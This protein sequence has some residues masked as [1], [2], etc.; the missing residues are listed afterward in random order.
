MAAPRLVF[1]SWIVAIVALGGVPFAASAADGGYEYRRSLSLH[2][3]EV[4]APGSNTR[5]L[6]HFPVLVH[7]VDPSFQRHPAGRVKDAAAR[8]VVFRGL[9]EETCRGPSPC[10]LPHELEHYDGASGELIVWVRVPAVRTAAAGADTVLA[11]DYG[12][13]GP[14]PGS[15]EPAAVWDAHYQAV[16]HLQDVSSDGGYTIRDSTSHRRHAEARGGIP[17]TAQARGVIAGS[18]GFDGV[19]DRADS[20]D[21]GSDQD[22]LTLEAWI[23]K[24][25]PKDARVLSKSDTVFTGPSYTWSLGVAND[26]P[27]VRL[28]TATQTVSL[29]GT[30]IRP[31]TWIH[32][33]TTYDG[34]TLRIFQDGELTAEQPLTGRIPRSAHPV[35]IANN[36]VGLSDRHWDG[37]LDEVR[38][39]SIARSP[40]WLRTQHRNQRAPRTFHAL[41]PEASLVS[42]TQPPETPAQPWALAVGCACGHTPDGGAGPLA[43]WLGLLAMARVFLRQGRATQA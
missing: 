32:L 27:R 10:T 17:A 35:V 5:A 21:F 43:I 24:T 23:F 19:D 16:W 40:D 1:L 8:D 31:S 41:G 14:A 33:A 11:I 22:G 36:D 12:L 18:L 13:E 15:P 3:S 28:T 4:G 38:V 37:R 2:R 25:G 9:D 20:V 30:R 34:A 29:D 7:V 42:S 26:L 39:S 6:L